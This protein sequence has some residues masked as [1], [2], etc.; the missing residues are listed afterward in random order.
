MSV[1]VSDDCV[2]RVLSQEALIS[3]SDSLIKQANEREVGFQAVDCYNVY[4]SPG[5]DVTI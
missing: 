2:W 4:N 3:Y 5:W 1:D